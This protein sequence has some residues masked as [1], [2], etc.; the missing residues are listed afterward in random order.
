MKTFLSTI[1]V[2]T[3]SFSDESIVIGLIAITSNEIYFEYSKS[4]IKLLDNIDKSKQLKGFVLSLLS[5]I[6]TTVHTKNKILS[7]N[8]QS[9]AINDV[10][11]SS[12]YFSYLSKYNN[13]MV[14]FSKPQAISHDFNQKDFTKY[15][16]NFVGLSIEEKKVNHTVSLHQKL[17]PIFNKS[18]LEEKADL[19]YTFDHKTFNKVVKDC[20]IPLITK[21]G[22]INAIQEIDFTNQAK[23]ITYNLYETKVLYDSLQEFSKN[24]NVVLSKLMIA[25]EEPALNTKEHDFFDMVWKEYSDIFDFVTPDKVDDFTDVILDSNF[26]KFS[27]LV[28]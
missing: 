15:F 1:S 24:V 26:T 8:Q 27:K 9:L 11:F 16:E 6:N 10:N 20:T 28:K 13:G 21:N 22:K 5:Q 7:K 12:D 3:N 17:K 18:G 14:S 25:F 19:G 4:K 2:K 23:S